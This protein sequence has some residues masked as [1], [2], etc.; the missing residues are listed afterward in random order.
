MR[1]SRPDLSVIKA[2]EGQ[3]GC[4]RCGGA[5]FAAEQMLAR[6]S[7]SQQLFQLDFI[8]SWFDVATNWFILICRWL[9]LAQDVLQL[10]GVPP[11]P[12][13]G[14]GL[15]RTRRRHLLQALL[16]QEVRTQRLRLRWWISL[17]SVRRHSVSPV[18][19][20]VLCPIASTRRIKSLGFSLRSHLY[21]VL[22]F[23]FS[24]F[25]K[26]RQGTGVHQHQHKIHPSGGG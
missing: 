2:G 7:V 4:P 11:R 12:R 15:R 20:C 1:P 24:F 8:I 14:A 13:F 26:E 6:G 16:R 10:Q 23:F 22:L 5:V 19:L 25:L 17:P 3:D 21:C 9:G 18:P